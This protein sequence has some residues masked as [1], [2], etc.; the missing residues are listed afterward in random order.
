MLCMTTQSDQPLSEDFSPEMTSPPL[1]PPRTTGLGA[2]GLRFDGLPA[3]ALVAAP[4]DWEPWT[5][6]WEQAPPE[7][8]AVQRF[9]ADEVLIDIEPGGQARVDRRAAST[10]L[11]LAAEPVADA[12]VHPH[13]ASTAVVTAA[14]FGRQS[15]HAGAFVLDGGVWA[16]VGDREHGKSSALAWL[17]AAGLAVFADDV[18]VIDAGRALAGP[19]CLDLRAGAARH[20]GMGCDIGL[21]GSR[22]R[23]RVRLPA[24]P[25]ELP[26]LGW[27][28][29][30]WSDDVDVRP[31][32]VAERLEVLLA[33]RGLRLPEHDPRPWLGLVA[34]PMV[35][36]SRPRDWAA[37][38][39]AMT[40]LVDRLAALA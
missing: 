26:F 21:V 38:D 28:I 4:E 36:L 19:R 2:Y 8:R 13:L 31:I 15:F 20:F 11:R 17:A 35:C 27:V 34:R 5:L 9:D 16:V 14:W 32:P 18:L 29:L 22:R 39:T 3:D 33:N 24:V 30:Q 12:L 37:A 1:H 6:C 40:A 23:W 25:A 10:T 7:G